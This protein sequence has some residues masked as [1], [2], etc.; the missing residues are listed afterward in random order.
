MHQLAYCQGSCI[1]LQLL[2]LSRSLYLPLVLKP[3]QLQSHASEYQLRRL[4]AILFEKQ[5]QD[6]PG[7][8]GAILA[9]EYNWIWTALPLLDAGNKSPQDGKQYFDAF[10]KEATTP[11]KALRITAKLLGKY[12]KL[13]QYTAH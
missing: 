2:L 10:V 9:R 3:V 8:Q 5:L 11:L 1:Q 6:L 4:K 7:G 12:E 13:R